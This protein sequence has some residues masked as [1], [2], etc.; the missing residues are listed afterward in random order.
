MVQR[1]AS[2]A[3]AARSSASAG[4]IA[5]LFSSASAV[6]YC[7][8]IA[9]YYCDFFNTRYI[10][11]EGQLLSADLCNHRD[12]R[13]AAFVRASSLHR[14]TCWSIRSQQKKLAEAMASSAA[15]AVVPPPQQHSGGASDT[16]RRSAAQRSTLC[17]ANRRHFFAAEAHDGLSISSPH[18]HIHTCRWRR[19]GSHVAVCADVVRW[20]RRRREQPRAAALAEAPARR[21]SSGSSRSG[22]S[23]AA[24]ELVAA[25][26]GVH[27]LRARRA[28]GR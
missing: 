11:L 10:S 26:A 13:A 8:R 2:N 5:I 6:L 14:H 21:W 4:T 27:V 22:G 28:A 7:Q 9:R 18:P 1:S 15:T 23:G 25:A 12:Q 24:G 16:R 20:R 17:A 3:Q 19:V